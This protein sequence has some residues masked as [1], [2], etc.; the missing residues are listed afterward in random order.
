MM[1]A[2]MR[3]Q[4]KPQSQAPSAVVE[5][6]VHD[7][8]YV[9]PPCEIGEGTQIWH[10]CHLM[11]HSRIGRHCN[12]G[13]NVM[14]GPNAVLG[15]YVR[16]QNNVSIYQGVVLEDRV[17]CG[18]S[19][20]FTN[21]LNPRSELSKKDQFRRTLVRR[22]ATLGA[23][24]T[25]IC[26]IEIGRYALVGAGAV[27][28]RNVP[29]YALLL[30]VPGRRAGWVCRCGETLPSPQADRSLECAVCGN[31]YRERAHAEELDVLLEVQSDD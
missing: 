31:L 15:N 5:A 19:M 26:G 12:L 30:G 4:L 20:V 2:D 1:G 11:A 18:P 3:V 16:V 29:A 24:S 9:D 14:V 25:V 17:F 8:A 27:A 10:F 23:N 22:G 13:Q 21:V 7:S 6:Q 28:T